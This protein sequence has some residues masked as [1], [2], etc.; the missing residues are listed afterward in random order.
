MANI[1]FR[2][3]IDSLRCL[4]VIAVITYHMNSSILPSGFVGVDIFLVISGYLITSIILKTDHQGNNKL[5]DFYLKRVKRILPLTYVVIFTSL[6]FGYALSSPSIYKA[7]AHSAFSAMLFIANFRFSLMGDYFGGMSNSPLLHLWSLSL[8][9]QFYIIW[10]MLIISVGGL[11]KRTTLGF[12]VGI[13][14]II[15][16]ALAQYS[17]SDSRLSTYA[18]FML[19]TRMI[20]LL[21][22]AFTAILILCFQLRISSL[23]SLIGVV[24]ISSSLFLIDPARFPGIISLIPCVGVSLVILSRPAARVN[25]LL[26]NKVALY[27]GKISFSL[28][29]WHWPMLVFINRVIPEQ[30]GSNLYASI[31]YVFTLLLVSSFSYYLIEEVFRRKKVTVKQTL[32]FYLLLPSILL[33]VLSYSISINSGL[34]Q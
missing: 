4:A 24:M 17:I 23:Y 12:L 16:I 20:G 30:V 15:S 19:P 31:T 1:K 18:Y 6:L 9:E 21:I 3:E 29:M 10:P 13:L 28:Y 7:E 2:P 33:T 22:G 32:L 27:I 34:P 11:K 8:E 25:D 26:S 14:L 5:S